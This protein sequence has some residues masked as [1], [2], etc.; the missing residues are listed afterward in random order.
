MTDKETECP[1]CDA[2]IKVQR[3][4]PKKLQGG[5]IYHFCSEECRD[6]FVEDPSQHTGGRRRRSLP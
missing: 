6:T 1:V 3:N 5:V 2:A 4:T